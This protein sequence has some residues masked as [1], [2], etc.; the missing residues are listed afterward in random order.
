MHVAHD[1][2]EK[3]HPRQD[4]RQH[5]R[6]RS[7]SSIRLD[8]GV[9]GREVVTVSLAEPRVMLLR[10]QPE[11]SCDPVSPDA[12]WRLTGCAMDGPLRVLVCSAGLELVYSRTGHIARATVAYAGA[13]VK[14]VGWGEADK[15]YVC[16]EFKLNGRAGGTASIA[17]TSLTASGQLVQTNANQNH[18]ASTAATIGFRMCEPGH[19]VEATV[20]DGVSTERCVTCPPGTSTMNTTETLTG[21][22]EL[23]V[24]DTLVDDLLVS[25]VVQLSRVHER[26]LPSQHREIEHVQRHLVIRD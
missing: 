18:T 26:E 16:G 21:C 24:V 1:H 14:A 25:D 15:G 6:R 19:I 8:E 12:P 7:I 11:T 2:Q 5:V 3:E 22:D 9:S 10:A 17:L 4:Q 20:T 13:Q 23:V